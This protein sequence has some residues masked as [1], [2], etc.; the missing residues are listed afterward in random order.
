[1]ALVHFLL[2][3]E[4]PDLFAADESPTAAGPSA[5]NA[6]F[7]AWLADANGRAQMRESSTDVYE[8]MWS[9]WTA[10]AVGKG[11]RFENIM[12]ADLEAYLLSRGGSDDLSPRYA[13]RLLRL[14][15]RVLSSHARAHALVGNTAAADLMAARPDIRFAN[16]HKAEELPD[17]L[18]AGQAR[19]LV[20]YLSVVRPGR[21]TAAQAWQEIRDRSSVALM[22]GAGL[23]PGEVRGLKTTD[24]V[25]EGGRSRDVPWKLRIDGNGNAPAR[26]T[27]VS[28]WAGQL[29]RYWLK[30]RAE[31]NIPGLMMFPSTKSTGKPWSKMSQY[32]A[33]KEVLH[34][35]GIEDAEGGSF[36]LRHTFALRQ[37]RRGKSAEDVARWL[38][39]SDADVMSRYR[40]VISVPIDVV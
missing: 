23:T 32:L 18:P 2:T 24:A 28:H 30:V 21:A 38:G 7:A 16:A 11:V 17:Y 1:M 3:S 22:L 27:P 9:A 39:V 13:W 15:D 26:E 25:T 14:V 5:Y 4:T 8:H 6:A 36:R 29:L 12:A 37:L 10:W 31:Q 19:Q 33:A 34:A 35:A 20:A 40:R